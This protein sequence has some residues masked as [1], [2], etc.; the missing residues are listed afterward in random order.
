MGVD[1]VGI[2]EVGVDKVGIDEMGIQKVG[3]DKVRT[4]EVGINQGCHRVDVSH[5]IVQH[6]LEPK[7][8]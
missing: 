8:P 4:D 7:L 1:K 6:T 5:F 3:I 2:N